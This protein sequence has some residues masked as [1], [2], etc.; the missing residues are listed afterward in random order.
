MDLGS[1][2]REK[3]GTIRPRTILKII[4]TYAVFGALWVIASDVFLYA[5]GGEV[6]QDAL[7]GVL[8]GLLVVGVSATL[9]YAI[10]SASGRNAMV[11]RD[12]FRERLHHYNLNANDA[13]LL[14]D[15]TGRILEANDRAAAMYGCP[16]QALTTKRIVD[17]VSDQARFGDCWRSLQENS[18]QRAEG[19]HRRSDGT[20][21]PVECSARRFELNG[22]P[23]IHIVIRDISERQEAERQLIRLKNA[24]A[25]LSQTNH[26]INQCSDRD[27]L[28]R[29]TCEIAVRHS[30]LQ[31][32]WIGVVDF[33]EEVVIPL[34]HAGPA[35]EYLH[36][37]QVSVNPNSPL[38]K[39][40]VGRAIIGRTP[41]V[42]NDLWNSEG[43]QPWSE[44]LKKSEIRSWAAFPIFEDG[45]ATAVL[46]L[47]STE[48]FSFVG[49]VA[50]V[51]REIADDLSIALDR[52]ALRLKQQLLESELERL[53]KAVE[54]SPVTIMIADSTGAI[55]YVN[56]A[57]TA[58]SGYSAQEVM[59]QNPRILKSGETSPEAYGAMWRHLA[60]G[61]AWSG[62]FHNKRKDGS[63]YWEEAVISPVKDSKG[64]TTHYIAVKQDVTA[65][66]DAEA[67]IRFLA[68]H[69]SLTELPNRL[70]AKDEMAEA[71]RWAD[72]SAGKAA[73]LFIDVDNFKR[74]NDSLGHA[75]GDQLLQVLARRLSGCLREGD[76]LSRVSGDEFL[77]I[78]PRVRNAKVVEAIAE[79]I[80]TELSSPLHVAG[81]DI[82][83]TVSIGAAV[84]PDDGSTFEDLQR[85]AD[86]AMYC[87][88]REGRNAF[89][90]YL[91]SMVTL[92]SECVS[93]KALV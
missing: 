39:S 78:A 77:V 56:P 23:F 87:A 29:Q 74:V 43:F 80:R 27:E 3:E 71:I 2:Q 58:T 83:T 52:L 11:E 24:Y 15:D 91:Q 53:K 9:L 54:Q 86:L 89:R 5:H 44:R 34:A 45:Q 37:L 63:L 28:F 13:V 75:I 22:S 48:A 79:R 20:Q 69:D 81:M 33:A 41:V 90:A 73:L 36:G 21:F 18:T 35:V 70:A 30:N 85:Q 4:L 7:L 49:D 46:A 66:R 57:F 60:N 10:I 25:A 61:Q 65:R 19:V 64:V 8:K 50:A 59:G 32:A 82:S 17:L 67:R 84:Y 26:C 31:L 42:V 76:A 93:L 55:K 12:G 72:R 14:L 47:Y 92:P 38:S 1:E 88:K 51:L 6:L 40:V 62:E 16:A 68:S